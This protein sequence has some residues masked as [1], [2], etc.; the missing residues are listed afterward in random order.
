M[1]A[2]EQQNRSVISSPDNSQTD[3]EMDNEDKNNI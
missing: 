1:S 2:A 3:K